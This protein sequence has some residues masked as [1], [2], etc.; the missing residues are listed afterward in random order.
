MSDV[1]VLDWDFVDGELQIVRERLKM[2]SGAILELPVPP[3]EVQGTGTASI[4]PRAKR[5]ADNRSN[6]P[7]GFRS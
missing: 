7:R 3:F 1:L 5:R 4:R 2:V 6:D